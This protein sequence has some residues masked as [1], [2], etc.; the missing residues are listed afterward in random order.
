[1]AISKTCYIKTSIRRNGSLRTVNVC[2][3]CVESAHELLRIAQQ[4]NF[5][6]YGMSLNLQLLSFS[7]NKSSQGEFYCYMNPIQ[8]SNQ[9]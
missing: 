8:R 5:H 2:E 6:D 7:I 1:M 4:G 3:V 9:L